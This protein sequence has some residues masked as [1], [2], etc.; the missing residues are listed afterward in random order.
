MRAYKLFLTRT[1]KIRAIR[2]MNRKCSDKVDPFRFSCLACFVTV[3]LTADLSKPVFAE[4][5]FNP[6]LLELDGPSQGKTDISLF[7]KGGQSPGTYRVDVW[8]NQQMVDSRD[9]E[10]K[11]VE[12][13]DGKKVL[14]PCLSASM[15]ESYGVKQALLT[16]ISATE[17]CVNL[18]VIEQASSDFDFARQ[19]LSLSFPQA[20]LDV[21]ARGYVSPDRWDQGINAL[22][23]NYSFSGAQNHAFNA[24]GEDNDNQYLNLRPGFNIGPWRLRNYSTWSR[25]SNGQSNWD[26]VYTLLQRD[27][28][29]LHGQMTLGDSNSSS[30]V[31]DSV[32]F[33]G[34]QIASDDEMLPDSLRG[35]APIVKGIARTNAEVTVRQNGYVIY[36]TSVAPGAFEITDMYPTGSSGD[37]DVTIKET[38]GSEQHLILPY[39]SLPVLQREGQLKYSVTG[40]G[41]RAYDSDINKTQFIQS[42][43][44]YGLPWNTTVYGGLQSAGDKY[45]ALAMGMGLNLGIVGALSADVTVAKS[46]PMNEDTRHG[47]SW[48]FRYSKNMVETGTNFA[49]AGYRYSTSGYYGMQELLDTWRNDDSYT[50]PDRRRNRFEISMNQN[51]WQDAGALSLSLVKEDYWS[52]DRDMRSMTAAYNNN[53]RGISYSLSYSYNRNTT[54]ED[55]DKVY[56]SDQI[57]S[58]NISI[59]LD[60]FMPD[61]WASYGMNT[62]RNGGTT[63]SAGLNGSALE[64][65]NLNWSVQEGYSTDQ[66]GTIG[67]A[68][69]DY[70]GSRGN[71]SAGYGY[72]ND[73]QRLNYSAQGGIVLH[74]DG[75][76]FSQPLGDT[77]A[78]VK[79]PGAGGVKVENQTGVRT[80]PRGYTTLP[81]LSVYREN[82]IDLEGE[83]LPDNVDLSLT[84]KTVVPTR[85]AVV[86]ANFDTHIGARAL[87]TLRKTDHQP[88]PFGAIVS[89]GSDKERIAAAMVGDDGQVYVTGL[90][91]QG[92]LQVQWGRLDGQHCRIHYQ[93]PAVDPK[94]G[95]VMLSGVCR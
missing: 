47:Q 79:A 84:S 45:S 59:P 44:I 88:V 31:F 94:S 56:Q 11:L 39:A 3:C 7:E 92:D 42:T 68:N 49:I 19:R 21:H 22:L 51:L 5:Y 86:R 37:L 63:H 2:K 70:K 52:T 48:R 8:L 77:V 14:Q 40:G 6:A 61:T 15:L 89:A 72:D 76:T 58:L 78:L 23:L 4:R 28:L 53:W 80:D 85:G 74:G 9:V 25:D 87:I 55:N 1:D 32:P 60:K 91:P 57:L 35:Y 81:Y 30:D 90:P 36:Q 34:A 93:L 24:T 38:D 65:K 12:S 27:I 16:G 13:A 33:R 46:S 75:I 20:S 66:T 43:A 62:R 10:F 50:A 64:D 29:A 17:T 71:I 95:I 82:H 54:S 67:N 41:Y 26:S 73:Y 83:S 18:S 69:L